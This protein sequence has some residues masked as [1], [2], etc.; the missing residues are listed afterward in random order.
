MCRDDAVKQG[1]EQGVSFL[2]SAYTSE[3]VVPVLSPV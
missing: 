3:A 1:V 2:A